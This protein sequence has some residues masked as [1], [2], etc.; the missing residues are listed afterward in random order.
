MNIIAR[1]AY[2]LR[3]ARLEIAEQDLAWMET[4]APEALQRQRDQVA[5]LRRRLNRQTHA[6]QDI[7]DR[8]ARQRKAGLLA[9]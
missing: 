2:R 7:A 6:A 5:A 4:H 9:H 1:I 3:R 8:C